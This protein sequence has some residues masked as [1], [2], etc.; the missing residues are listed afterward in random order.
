[1][2]HQTQHYHQTFFTATINKWIKA[3]QYDDCKQIIINSLTFLM[4]KKRINI[5]L[6]S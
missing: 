5:P 6:S 2:K 4:D 3:L 1:M